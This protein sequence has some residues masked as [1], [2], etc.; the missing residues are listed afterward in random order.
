M[1]GWLGR[2]LLTSLALD[3][4]AVLRLPAHPAYRPWRLLII[5][6]ALATLLPVE[7]RA[8]INIER[9]RTQDEGLSASAD[10]AF[11]FRSGNSDLFDVSV[12]GQVNHRNDKRFIL[13][14]ARV[15][16][17]ESNG[18]T[19]NS[20]AFAHLRLTQWF[21]TLGAGELFGQL[22]NDRFTLLQLRSLIGSGIRLRLA[23]T[24]QVSAFL[25][26]AAMYEIEDLDAD[27][28]TVHPSRS[29]VV[30]WSNY[31]SF[32][33]KISESA[34]FS[35]TVYAQPQVDAFSDVRLLQDAALNFDITESVSFRV[36][37]RQRFD[38]RPPDDIERH[39]AFVENGI[40]VRF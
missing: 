14:I 30:R 17:G 33:W 1:S 21:G 19:Y 35:T 22:E 11:A 2:N 24:G 40:R 32:S 13:G 29:R 12:G 38:N 37:F 23:E 34:S 39:D 10:V 20:S 15:R 36:V 25:G 4:F 27:K 18:T 26:S 6:L 5:A 9:L 7:A 28:V 31:L 3:V 16:Y 8:Q